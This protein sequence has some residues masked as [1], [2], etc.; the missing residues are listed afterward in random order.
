M[1]GGF[2]IGGERVQA[3]GLA[4][5]NFL[6]EPRLGLLPRDRAPRPPRTWI[7]LI[8]LHTTK[9]IWP[10]EVRP[11]RGPEANVE[12]RIA[13]LW[14]NDKRSASAHLSVDSDGSIGCHADLRDEIAY[15]DPGS[16]RASIGIELYQRRIVTNADRAE[17]LGVLY[18]HQIA[19]MVRLVDFLTAEFGIQRQVASPAIH[20]TIPRLERGESDVVGIAGH[21][22]A[23]R[24]RGRGDP[25]DQPLQALLDAG[26]EEIRFDHD[27][28]DRWRH[29]QR[30]GAMPTEHVDGIA[31]PATRAMLERENFADGLWVPRPPL[32]V[33]RSR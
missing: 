8:L 31:G 13:E 21:R 1:T 14:R 19:A 10:C 3:A 17:M 22:H 29:R 25:G 33:T 5:R 9:G 4:V 30:S 15:H 6:D 23:S 2:V 26:Y 12:E 24:E 7:R 11:G 18:E 20:G 28:I 32:S 27:D 16:N